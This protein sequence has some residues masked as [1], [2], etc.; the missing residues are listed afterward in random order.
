[1][2][3]F[4]WQICEVNQ[5]K[6]A[7]PKSEDMQMFKNFELTRPDWDRSHD[8]IKKGHFVVVVNVIEQP[9]STGH[10]EGTTF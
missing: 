5:H 7:N 2:C 3:S 10:F 8:W 6:Q 4:T 9:M 1:M